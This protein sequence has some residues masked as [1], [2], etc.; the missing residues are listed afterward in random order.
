ME[1]ASPLT[2][3]GEATEDENENAHG[4]HRNGKDRANSQL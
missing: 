4:Y 1:P 3:S 2:S